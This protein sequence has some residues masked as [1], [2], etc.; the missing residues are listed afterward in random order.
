MI[1]FMH[2]CPFFQ[3]RENRHFKSNFTLRCTYLN[4]Y[5]YP[6][7]QVTC[8]KHVNIINHCEANNFNFLVLL[9]TKNCYLALTEN[10]LF[11]PSGP[12]SQ[13]RSHISL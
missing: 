2:S 10:L 12:F 7:L 13:S 6:R 1:I 3:F 9:K 4:K 11:I 5:L 8:Y